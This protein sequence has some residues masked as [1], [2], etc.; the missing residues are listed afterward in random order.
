MY[1]QRAVVLAIITLSGNTVMLGFSY[2]HC[3]CSFLV[4]IVEQIALAE[5]ARAFPVKQKTRSPDSL[6]PVWILL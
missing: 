3:L 5:A 2:V 6:L 1:G 4:G